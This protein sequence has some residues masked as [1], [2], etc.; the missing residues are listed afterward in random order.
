MVSREWT[1]PWTNM[2][3]LAKI[4]RHYWKERLKI[5]NTAKFGSDTS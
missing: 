4:R 1:L 3:K 2:D 5:S